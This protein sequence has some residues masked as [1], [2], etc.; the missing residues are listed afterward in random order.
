MGCQV[1]G[2]A[3]EAIG[4]YRT[5]S[6]WGL[7]VNQVQFKG[8][9][10][11]ITSDGFQWFQLHW[12]HRLPSELGGHSPRNLFHQGARERLPSGEKP[13]GASVKGGRHGQRPEHKDLAVNASYWLR[14]CTACHTFQTMRPG[15]ASLHLGPL[16][17]C[18]PCT[19]WPWGCPLTPKFLFYNSKFV[20]LSS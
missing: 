16:H 8:R 11:M 7:G 14:A 4:G 5:T 3:A 2:E 17:Q 18:Q 1:E 13:P 15:S 9:K 12:E 19:K 20:W 10:Q 6:D